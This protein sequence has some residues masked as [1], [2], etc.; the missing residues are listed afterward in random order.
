MDAPRERRHLRIN[1][2][3]KVQLCKVDYLDSAEYFPFWEEAHRRGVPV[4]MHP[5]NSPCYRASA[6]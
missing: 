4:F 2:W 3:T 5:S 1:D 6:T